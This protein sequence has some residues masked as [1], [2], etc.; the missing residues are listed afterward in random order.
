MLEGELKSRLT[1]TNGSVILH[2]D[3]SV[4]WEHGIFVADIAT[5]LEAKVIVATKPK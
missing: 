5:K 3:K 1:G 2:I 4:P